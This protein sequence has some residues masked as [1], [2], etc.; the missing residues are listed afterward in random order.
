MSKKNAI[1][2]IL[3]RDG[4]STKES[5]FLRG[6]L[7][8]DYMSKYYNLFINKYEFSGLERDQEIFLK[9]ALWFDGYTIAFAIIKPTQKF[10]GTDANIFSNGVL[11]FAQGAPTNYNMFDMPTRFKLIN[12]R[13]VPYIPSD[14]MVNHENCVYCY[15][16]SDYRAICETVQHK[17]EQIVEDEMTIRTQLIAQKLSACLETDADGAQ[18]ARDLRDGILSDDPLRLVKVKEVDHVKSLS[19]Q[20]LQFNVQAIY[21][22]KKSLEGEIMTLLGIDNMD[23]NKAERVGADEANANNEIINESGDSVMDNLKAFCDE[24][25][26]VLKIPLTVTLKHEKAVSIHDP[27]PRSDPS[28]E[29]NQ[30]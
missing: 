7:I 11:G 19:P 5:S 24:I 29:E 8:D 20:G 30:K 10:L 1:R 16:Q 21:S 9:R 4:D 17:V 3:P 22:H 2:Y 26:S 27:Q 15:A 23:I 18:D 6:S 12:T 14:F 13:G 25:S 28:P